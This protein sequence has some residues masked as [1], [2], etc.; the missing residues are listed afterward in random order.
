[1]RRAIAAKNLA[2]EVFKYACAPATV[3][4]KS[5]PNIGALQFAKMLTL[6]TSR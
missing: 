1:L 2:R 3:E 5:A 4:A 6:G